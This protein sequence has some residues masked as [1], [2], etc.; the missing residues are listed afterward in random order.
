MAA[1]LRRAGIADFAVLG[2]AQG[3]ALDFDEEAD[4]WT[5]RTADGRGLR[6]RLVVVTAGSPH[7]PARFAGLHIT[8]TRGLSLRDAWSARPSAFLGVAVHGFPNLFL[9]AGP[10]SPVGQGRTGP[11]LEAQAR[12]I[13]Q[14]VQLLRRSAADRIEVRSA[15]QHEFERRVRA[16]RLGA[17]SVSNQR[18]E[19]TV[20]WPGSSASYRRAVRRLDPRHFDLTVASERVAAYEYSGP[21]LLDAPGAEV[22]VTVTLNG[23]PDPIDGRYHW[24]G[25]VSAADGSELPDPGRGHVHLTLPGGTPAAATLQERDPW[26]NLRIT[27]VGAPPFPLES[28]AA[29]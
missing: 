16:R 19:E 23:H 6:P 3:A 27:G 1:E 18:S 25:R 14:G 22:P 17:Q 8:G 4:R 13:R 2:E 11:V 5:V 9:V 26:G 7:D 29:H 20:G 12:Y 15:T 10:N 24:Y 28:A 21:A